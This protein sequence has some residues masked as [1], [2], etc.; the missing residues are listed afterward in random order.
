MFLLWYNL[1]SGLEG[2]YVVIASP[3]PP[4][5]GGDGR[6]SSCGL[7]NTVT[8]TFIF[9]VVATLV[10]RAYRAV[11]SVNSLTCMFQLYT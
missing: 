1:G 6:R 7:P 8:N 2:S 4:M 5:Q 9:Q 10:S 11:D 3:R